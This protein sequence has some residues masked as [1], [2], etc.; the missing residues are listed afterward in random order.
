MKEHSSIDEKPIIVR[1]SKVILNLRFSIIFFV[2]L[3]FSFSPNVNAAEIWVSTKGSDMNPGTLAKPFATLDAALRKARELRR[4]EDPSIAGGIYICMHGG[5][6]TLDEPVFIRP[7]D[8]GTEGS[9]TRIIAA[10]NERPLLSGG[11]EVKGWK[12]VDKDVPGLSSIACKNV[13]VTEAPVACGNMFDFRQLWVNGTKA[14]RARD[15]NNDSLPRITSW[16]KKTGE[17]GIP[18]AWMKRF[19][20][21]NSGDP[22]SSFQRPESMEF[23]IHQMWAIA[24]LRVK[25]MRLDGNQVLVSFQ[26]PEAR[27]QAEHPW[28]TPAMADSVRSPFYMSNALEFLDQPGEWYLDVKANKL[29]YWPRKG[30]NMKTA[31]VVAPYLE[32]IVDF[33][34]TLDSQVSYVSF[35]GIS[36][37]YTTWMRPS[38]QGHVPIQAGMYMLDAYKLRPP[39]VP[40]NPNKGIENQA[41]IGRPASAVQL[42]GV[43]H[44]AFDRCRFEH[45]GSCG[46]DYKW[47][48]FGDTIKGCLFRDISG[49]G[50]QAG[51]FSDPGME[52]HLPYDP[53][54]KR[55][56]CTSLTISNNLVTDVTN[57]DW[58]CVGIAAGYVRGINIE[59]NEV[60]EVSYTGISLGWGWTK[61]VNCMRDNKVHA[62]YIHNYAKHMYDVAGIYTLSVQPKTTINEN[63][64]DSIYHPAYVHDPHHWF[65]LYTDEGSSFITLK[66]NWCPAEKFLANAN[67]PG[68]TWEN[69]GPEVSEEIKSK[70]GIEPEYRSILKEK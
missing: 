17:M 43:N 48:T 1:K 10:V 8:S 2:V 19:V 31:S 27:I 45:M 61:A 58:G 11:V 20:K 51:C 26:E 5:V 55:E 38:L 4:L 59:H 47:S 70:A 62:N 29:Y 13:W 53:A 33:E 41:W 37:G 46:I 23:T 52:T 9:P 44:T 15:A 14:I 67:G 64:V 54:D 68:N 18:A 39:G 63:V 40:G 42:K 60:S 36:F 32:T 56:V 24:D 50:I 22:F 16:N 25:S 30:E 3:L 34:G 57:E 12:K 69:N 66:D 6:Y 35:E 49:N 28:P 65:Y 21:M 7:E